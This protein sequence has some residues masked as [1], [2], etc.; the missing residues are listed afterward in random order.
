MIGI[1]LRISLLALAAGSVWI[2]GLFATTDRAWALMG[3]P[4]E[5]YPELF[6]LLLALPLA[7]AAFTG[8]AAWAWT[9]FRKQVTG[10]LMQVV[11]A[12]ALVA[13]AL[14]AWWAVQ[15]FM[16]YEDHAPDTGSW[17]EVVSTV[18]FLGSPVLMVVQF[19]LS[20]AVVASASRAGA[21]SAR[22]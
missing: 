3:K 9:G 14:S 13:L 22:R 19:V 20:I 7:L 12:I 8:A 2:N 21:R 6:Y 5:V 16:G 10:R 11:L 15:P 18:L 4:A 17:T 1:V